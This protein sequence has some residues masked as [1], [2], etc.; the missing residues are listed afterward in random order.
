M[1]A[2]HMVTTT[3]STSQYARSIVREFRILQHGSRTK[4][5]SQIRCLWAL[6]QVP[7][8]LGQIFRFVWSTGEFFSKLPQQE[9]ALETEVLKSKPY[10]K[11]PGS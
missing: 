10:T 6:L 11:N 7:V 5:T 8:T 1:L 3:R 2:A 4:G 9:G